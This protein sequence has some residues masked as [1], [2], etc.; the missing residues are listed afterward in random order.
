MYP[1]D[2]KRG[3]HMR[4]P[5]RKFGDVIYHHGIYLGDETVIHFRK[6]VPFGT[7]VIERTDIDFFADGRWEDVEVVPHRMS[8]SPDQVV[9]RANH[10]LKNRGQIPYSF[11]KDN[12]EH[13]ANWCK[14]GEFRSQQV[15]D[16]AELLDR[17][18]YWTDILGTVAT[19]LL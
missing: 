19:S 15:E 14:C 13:I 17:V 4:V 10:C 8:F 2:L 6:D 12:C 3:D 11:L 5:V 18:T 9:E 1:E 7:P 16:G